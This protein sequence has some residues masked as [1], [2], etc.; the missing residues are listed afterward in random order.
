MDKAS[1]ISE[2][3]ENQRFKALVGT[4]TK[5]AADFLTSHRDVDA[6]M[7]AQAFLKCGLEVIAYNTQHPAQRTILQ[8]LLNDVTACLDT[9]DHVERLNT[10]GGDPDRAN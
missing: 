6:I 10:L 5:A 7:L 2:E 4:V 9:I 3:V 1:M 8:G